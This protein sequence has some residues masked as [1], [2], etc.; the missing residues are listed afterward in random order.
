MRLKLDENLG[1][2]IAESL[3]N[4]GHDVARSGM[5]N[6]AGRTTTRSSHAAGRRGRCLVTLDLDF[7][8]VLRFPPEQTEGLAVLRPAGKPTL[9]ALG[10]LA[11]QLV[12]ALSRESVAGRLW[13]IEPGRIRVH[14]SPGKE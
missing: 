2:R 3:R 13:I 4:A 10:R 7:S 14:E 5:R 1:W 9:A 8:N 12:E 6:S 11:G